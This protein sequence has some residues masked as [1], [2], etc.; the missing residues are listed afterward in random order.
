[1]DAALYKEANKAIQNGH[2]NR[3]YYIIKNGTFTLL[4]PF[5]NIV[6]LV[7]K[8]APLSTFVQVIRQW[9]SCYEVMEHFFFHH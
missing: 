4:I 5:D 7:L 3:N 9:E 8:C 2:Q 1:M 6:R